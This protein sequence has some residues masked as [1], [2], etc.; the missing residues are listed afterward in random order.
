MCVRKHCAY[1]D[2]S[3]LELFLF[4]GCALPDLVCLVLPHLVLPDDHS[5]VECARIGDDA[6]DIRSDVVEVGEKH[7]GVDVFDD[8]PRGFLEHLQGG[9][10]HGNRQKVLHPPA[11]VDE[12]VR[13]A[14]VLDELAYSKF[15]A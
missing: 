7:G 6:R 10:V 1:V 11:N 15:L 4:S 2:A 8:L 5:L 13:N 9:L 3:R 14:E 12:R